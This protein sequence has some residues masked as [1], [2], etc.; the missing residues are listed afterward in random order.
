MLCNCFIL[1]VVFKVLKIKSVSISCGYD[2]MAFCFDHLCGRCYYN[3][4]AINL[5]FVLLFR[6][7]LRM[8]RHE[9]EIAF[10]VHRQS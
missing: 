6:V 2:K 7:Y 1:L 4:V 5:C 9:V 10:K 8:S 3:I